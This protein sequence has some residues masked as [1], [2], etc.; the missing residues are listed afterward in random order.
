MTAKRLV[1]KREENPPDASVEPTQG[2]APKLKELVPRPPLERF[3]SSKSG[4][5]LSVTDLISPA[6][7]ELQYFYNLTMPWRKKTTVAMRQGSKVHKTLEDQVHRTVPIDVQTKEDAWSL[8][9]WNIIQGLRTLRE[10]GMTR[11]LQVLG[12]IDGQVVCGVIDEL[13]YI[14]PDRVLEQGSRPMIIEK[15]PTASQIR[16]PNLLKQRRHSAVEGSGDVVRKKS[17]LLEKTPSI[18]LTDVKTRGAKSLPQGSSFRPTLIQL[19]LYHRLLSDLADNRTDPAV[20]F[21]RI[22]LR[23]NAPFSAALFAQIAATND[24]TCYDVP[25]DSPI[26]S[27][28]SSSE[29]AEPES[30]AT[31]IPQDTLQLFRSHNSLHQLWKLL[32]DEIAL[33]MPE[34]AASIGRVLNVEYRAQL[35]GAIMGHKTFLHDNNMLQHYLEDCMRWWKGEREARGVCEEEAFKCGWCEFAEEC[36]WRKNKIEEATEVFRSRTRSEV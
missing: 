11:E 7:C 20:V 3:R 15:T 26:P 8:K 17:R 16:L 24:E 27:E 29:P 12:I 6:W 30:S 14:C 19:M 22:G 1:R 23:P 9:I 31:T 10:T 2:P 21:D 4:K 34:G 32:T 25:S 36:D 33:T 18:Y 13:S 35:D 28:D 5:T